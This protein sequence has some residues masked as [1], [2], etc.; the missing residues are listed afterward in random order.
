MPK[1][2]RVLNSY[3]VFA[4][5]LRKNCP[6]VP[7]TAVNADVPLPTKTPVSVDAPEPPLDT[8]SVPLQ[9]KVSD[10]ARIRDV[11]GTRGIRH[12]SFGVLTTL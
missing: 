11:A 5:F 3:A 10:T 4:R 12:M 8:A 9:P 7:T 2:W 1:A 6:A